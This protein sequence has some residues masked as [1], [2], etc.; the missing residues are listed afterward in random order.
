MKNIRRSV[1]SLKKT[2]T[3]ALLRMKRD[4]VRKR[5]WKS[6]KRYIIA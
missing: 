2:A 6:Q 3:G 1:V 5:V 4:T